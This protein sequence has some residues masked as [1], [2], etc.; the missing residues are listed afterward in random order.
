VGTPR[1]AWHDLASVCCKT[2]CS[3]P[4]VAK[5]GAGHSSNHAQLFAWTAYPSI[6]DRLFISMA[7]NEDLSKQGAGTGTS[8]AKRLREHFCRG[9]KLDVGR[10]AQLRVDWLRAAQA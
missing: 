10:A 4:F 2:N 7:S 9:R 1:T 8:C 6:C 5:S 3:I